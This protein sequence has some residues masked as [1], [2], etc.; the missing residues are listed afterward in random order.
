MFSNNL[1]ARRSRYEWAQK[2]AALALVIVM[3]VALFDGGRLWDWAA[4]NPRGNELLF[5]ASGE[6]SG[7]DVDRALAQGADI[8]ARSMTDCTPLM[9]AS[10]AGDVSAVRELLA[11]GADVSLRAGTGID[12]LHMAVVN[13]NREVVEMLLSAG[14][15]PNLLTAGGETSLDVALRMQLD[16]IAALLMANGGKRAGDFKLASASSPSL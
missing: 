15:N 7:D 2:L 5:C 4:E 8:N 14:A 9:I 1:G 3:A 6:G 11:R 12:A 10:G 13:S 16:R